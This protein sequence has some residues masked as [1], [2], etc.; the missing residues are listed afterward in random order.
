MG[1]YILFELTRIA[2][3][4]NGQW[5]LKTKDIPDWAQKVIEHDQKND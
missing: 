1:K 4:Q 3:Y 2:V 5:V